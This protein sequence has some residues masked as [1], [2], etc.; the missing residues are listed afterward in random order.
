MWRAAI[1]EPGRESRILTDRADVAPPATSSPGVLWLDLVASTAE[2]FSVLSRVFRLD[3]LIIE[4]CAAEL[5]HPKLDVY[6]DVLFLVVHGLR[7]GARRGEIQTPELDVVLGARYL[8]TYRMEDM[9][10]VDEVW[11]KAMRAASGHAEG[12]PS[13]LQRILAAQATAHLREVERLQDDVLEIERELFDRARTGASLTLAEKLFDI[14][15]DLARLRSIMGNQRDVVYRLSR[16]ESSL[17]ST[18]LTMQY[19]DVHDDLHRAT[20]MLDVLREVSTTAL[21][22]HL[23]LATHRTNEIVRVLT[24]LAT[25][26]L[27]LTLVTGWYGMNFRHMLGFDWKL[28]EIYVLG[29]FCAISAGLWF[30]LRRRHWL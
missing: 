27:P 9:R 1:L 6:D 22:T 4:D 30:F 19:R 20:E 3:P 2:E 26:I 25:F 17:V 29:L 14:K 8:I 13:I 11:E 21:D 18:A 23:M 24:V 15:I 12:A 10:S 7:L 28:G 5:H 16:G